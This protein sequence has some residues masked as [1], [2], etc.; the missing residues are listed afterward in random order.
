MVQDP[1][2]INT[3]STEG[4]DAH[5]CV[6][7]VSFLLVMLNH[8][9]SVRCRVLP[10]QL[11]MKPTATATATAAAAA[12]FGS[13][14]SSNSSSSLSRRIN[15]ATSLAPNG[16]AATSYPAAASHA[17]AFADEFDIF[18]TG[19]PPAGITHRTLEFIF[20]TAGQVVRSFIA[21]AYVCIK[22]SDPRVADGLLG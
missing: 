3:W 11:F 4:Y 19:C 20:F 21:P 6:S 13:S 14:S 22:F 9:V 5:L 10:A 8:G 18:A 16:E 1:A 15:P 2:E 17:P 12:G 7:V